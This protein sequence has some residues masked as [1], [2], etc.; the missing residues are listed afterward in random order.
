[1][2]EDEMDSVGVSLSKL[3]EMVKDREGPPWGHKESDSTE[4][5]A[6]KP[7]EGL[8]QQHGFICLL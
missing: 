3:E 8:E 2:T 5:Q 1:M 6:G 4:Q 7:L